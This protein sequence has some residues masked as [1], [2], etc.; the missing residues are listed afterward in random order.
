MSDTTDNGRKAAQEKLSARMRM[1]MQG[2]EWA[3]LGARAGRKALSAGLK[4][5]VPLMEA[6]AGV[7]A[8]EFKP[9]TDRKGSPVG[10]NTMLELDFGQTQVVRAAGAKLFAETLEIA[11]VTHPAYEGAPVYSAAIVNGTRPPIH[12]AHLISA[13]RLAQEVFRPEPG[14]EQPAPE[15]DP[16]R[17]VLFMAVAPG[18]YVAA[19]GPQSPAQI[20]RAAMRERSYNPPPLAIMANNNQ[21]VAQPLAMAAASASRSMTAVVPH[22]AGSG[23]MAAAGARSGCGGGRGCRCGCSCGGGA[24]HCSCGRCRH[25]QFGPPRYNDDGSCKSVGTISCETQWRM[26]DCLKFAFCDTLRCMA[27]EMC[28]DGKFK[29]DSNLGDCVEIFLCSLISCLPEAICPESEKDPCRPTAATP[30]CGCNFAVQE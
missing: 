3:A 6:Y 21:P 28:E 22:A 27:E 7:R 11:S 25:Y 17:T 26:R 20:R 30:G 9:P 23:A 8:R 29:E 16:Q 1:L 12:L 13:Y 2:L 14:E 19:T 5:S 15:I 10:G 24:G 18:E 4:A